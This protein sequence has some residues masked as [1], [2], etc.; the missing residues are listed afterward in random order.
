MSSRN[1]IRRDGD[2]RPGNLLKLEATTEIVQESPNNRGDSID[3]GA[4]TIVEI[5]FTAEELIYED[6]WI[7]LLRRV[8]E[9]NDRQG[10]ELRG[11]YKNAQ[12][13]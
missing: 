2:C 10:I 1:L 4:R 11:P 6:I 3:T 5:D 12:W 13:S 9:R 8:I 7:D